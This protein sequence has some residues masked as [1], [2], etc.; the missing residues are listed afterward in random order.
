[1][2]RPR[3]ADRAASRNRFGNGGDGLQ[4]RPRAARSGG[5][6]RASAATP[7]PSG[8]RGRTRKPPLPRRRARRPGVPRG[9]PSARPRRRVMRD[10]PAPWR[11]I[12]RTP[13]GAER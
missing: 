8:R 4:R 11:E 1:V 5:A 12:P 9:D 7:P 2:P 6:T 3:A 10:R 13:N